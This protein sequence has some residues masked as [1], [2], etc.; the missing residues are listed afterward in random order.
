MEDG[1]HFKIGNGATS[2]WYEP[3]LLKDPVCH[4]VPFVQIQ[5]I[6]LQIRDII[7][8]DGGNL[9]NVYTMLPQDV[10]SKILEMT[11]HLV[12][13]VTDNWI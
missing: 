4:L 6:D 2:M 13:D 10:R 1:L 5:D 8:T 7:I 11:T 12:D 3:W 9:Q